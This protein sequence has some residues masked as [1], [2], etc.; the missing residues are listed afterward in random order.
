MP[1]YLQLLGL[2]VLP[3]LAAC[4]G[5]DGGVQS[6][7]TPTPTPPPTSLPL[8]GSAALQTAASTRLTRGPGVLYDGLIM[9]QDGQRVTISYDAGSG[10]YTL[11]DEVASASFQ[12][13]DRTSSSN[14]TDEYLKNGSGATD[15]LK[16][17]GNLRTAPAAG[18]P[19]AL[20]YVTFGKWTHTDTVANRTR[21][22]S[23]VA[24]F[25]TPVADMPRS[26]SAT[27]QTIVSA[28]AL[29]HGVGATIPFSDVTG[30]ATFSANFANNSVNTALSLPAGT[31]SGPGTIVENRFTGTFASSSPYFTGGRFAG[32]FFGPAAQ[33]MGYS[34]DIELY[35]PDPYAGAAVSPTS[36]V[37][38]G[39]VAGR[40]P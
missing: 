5:G 21:E 35:N 8:A 6:T 38:S 3:L 40:K 24:G 23:V 9:Q 11:S 22:T 29:A 36:T 18:A 12:A 28:T 14:Y 19:L 13:S 37:I 39:T 30:T 15:R 4:G 27:Y 16:V 10:T 31:F 20:S 17:Y 32:G 26:G 34:F 25:A 7:P 1:K 33:E 2:C